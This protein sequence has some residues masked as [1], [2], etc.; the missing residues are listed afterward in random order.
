VYPGH[1]C[2][3]E[4]GANRAMQSHQVQWLGDHFDI[5]P[6][7]QLRQGAVDF[8]AGMQDANERYAAW[9]LRAGK[10]LILTKLT[11]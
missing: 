5:R 9:G 3:N 2:I 8:V 11:E 1:A 6:L 4:K 7:A 10:T